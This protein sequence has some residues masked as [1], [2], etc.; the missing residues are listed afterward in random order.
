M[1]VS[2]PQEAPLGY[3]K[4]NWAL[5]AETLHAN[6]INWVPL[7]G[8]VCPSWD[9]QGANQGNTRRHKAELGAFRV[10]VCVHV[11]QGSNRGNRRC[12]KAT[13]NVPLGHAGSYLG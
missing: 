10:G 12:L 5:P 11:S 13:H 8:S 9:S 7:G 6:G 1:L 3:G 2:R 4:G